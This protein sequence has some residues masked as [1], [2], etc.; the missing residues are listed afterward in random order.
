MSE[1]VSVK[2][3]IGTAS[4]EPTPT[5]PKSAE[6]AP[7][8]KFKLNA[9]QIGA[10][11]F[12]VL[13]AI[14]C[15]ALAPVTSAAG[16]LWALFPPVVAI[17]LALITK[18]V[19]S[20][21]LIGTLVGAALAAK[22]SPAATMDYLIN[23]A[24]IS[25]VS[26]TAG[27]FLFLVFLGIIVSLLNKSGGSAAFGRWAQSHIKTRV[28]AMLATFALGVLIFI[29]DYFNCLTVGAV[30]KPVTDTHKISRAKLAYL[31]DATAAPICMIAPISSWAA[32]VSGAVGDNAAGISGIKLFCMAIPYNFYSLL[33]LV[34]VIAIS[35]MQFDYGPM[36]RH[37]WNALNRGDFFTE[38][39]RAETVEVKA[40][41]KSRIMD[42]V[43]PV[44]VLIFC[45]A[46]AMLYV[47]GFFSGVDFITAFS[48]TDA[49]VAL[50]WGAIIALVF[51]IIYLLARKLISFKEAMTS[52]P[53][54]FIAMIAPIIILT[55]ATSLK[56]LTTG[57]EILNA[58]GFV[59]GAMSG[60]AGGLESMLPAIIFLVAVFIAFATGT[61]WGTFGI[62]IPIVCNVFQDPSNPLFIIGVSACLAGAVCGDHCS[63]ISDTTIMSSA[64]AECNHL[65]HVNTQLP[66]ALTVA[67]VSFVSFII[68]GFLKNVWF[69]LPIA[70]L[71]TLGTLLV[72]KGTIG[73]KEFDPDKASKGLLSQETLDRMND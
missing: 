65:N 41:E 63:P 67:G 55:L 34:F 38:G 2:V 42:L 33:S 14:I 58:K 23:D 32:A 3:N 37:E 1:K 27:I 62:L 4:T 10:I 30:M 11:C 7:K 29:D 54:G 20:S 22:F 61:S 44:I 48:D 16:T 39:E 70:I 56:N 28:G 52:I 51:T 13:F 24:M 64:G 18:E 25:A 59:A 69:S 46:A 57:E 73:K 26:G 43:L 9:I 8:K 6:P 49:T 31:I 53:E 5:E 19:Y 66:Y 36:R 15:A 60:V 17:G 68:A 45:C 21:L 50:P 35:K 47:G 72:M 40:N 71:L 12:V